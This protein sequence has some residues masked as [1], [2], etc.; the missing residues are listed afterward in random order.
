MTFL[1]RIFM[2]LFVLGARLGAK[3]KPKLWLFTEGR[4][5]GYGDLQEIRTTSSKVVWMHCASLGEFEQGRPVVEEFKSRHPEYDIYITFFSP[6][7]YEVRKDYQQ[8]AWVGYLPYDRPGDVQAFLRA[9]RPDVALMVKYEVWPVLFQALG[10]MGIPVIMFSAIFRPGHRYFKWYGGLFRKAL[11]SVSHFYV[12]NEKS[13]DLLAGIG[14]TNSTLAGDTRFDRVAHIAAHSKGVPMISE[15]VQDATVL[16]AGSTWLPD[17]KLLSTFDAQSDQSFKVIIAPHEIGEDHIAQIEHLWG[18]RTL[19]YSK[20]SISHLADARILIIDNIGF[21]SRL[22]QYAHFAIIGG[23][24]GAGIHNTLEA[25]AFGLP[26]IIGPNYTRFQEA[27]DLDAIGGALVVHNQDE[28]NA[29]CAKLM[30]PEERAERSEAIRR[31]CRNKQ[32]A[33]AMIVSG[34]EAKLL[35]VAQ[36][37]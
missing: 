8:A 12:Q 22:Y 6:S 25:A 17:E 32:G 35:E 4:K 20:A 19:R 37:A 7:G 27:V 31:Y 16:I 9:L 18:G 1:Y 30:I 34:I 13:V 33:T 26:V 2:E 21:L 24:F 5:Q 11:Q 28:F 15:F 36:G 14:L 10:Q 3:H 23:G 29:A